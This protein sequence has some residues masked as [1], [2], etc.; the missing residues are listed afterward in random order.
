MERVNWNA[1]NPVLYCFIW[2]IYFIKAY[3]FTKKSK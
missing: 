1:A 3:I 2:L